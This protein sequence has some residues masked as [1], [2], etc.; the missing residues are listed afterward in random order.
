MIKHRRAAERA[1]EM[2]DHIEEPLVGPLHVLEDEDERLHV[3]Q[4]LRPAERSPR[5]LCAFHHVLRRAEHSERHAEQIRDGLALAGQAQLLE[6]LGCRVVVGDAGG[7][8]DHRRDRPE[9]DAFAVRQGSSREDRRALDARREL[10]DEPGLADARVA[11]H[12]REMCA[13]VTGRPVVGV[14]QQALLVL[15]TDEACLWPALAGLQH[16]GRPPGP[17][18]FPGARLDGPCVLDLD[19]A[20]GQP[21]CTWAEHDRAR[22]SRLLQSRRHVDRLAGDERRIDVLD[23]Q[24]SRLDPDPDV[25]PEVVHRLEDCEGCSEGALRVVLVSLRHAEGRHDRVAGELL[26]RTAM[27]LDACGR[28]REIACDAAAHHLGVARADERRRV[29]EIDEEH[30]RKLAFHTTILESGG[31]EPER[32]FR[33]VRQASKSRSTLLRLSLRERT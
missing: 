9:R 12:R 22:A 21:A 26:D 31:V 2:L 27:A 8:F 13:P 24:L 16:A 10:L 15:A 32:D 5:D 1:S 11:E 7:G 33:Y 14:A 4:L 6:R 19:R 25:E 28:L 20:D 29:D 30:G 23:D 3:R 18:L 17:D